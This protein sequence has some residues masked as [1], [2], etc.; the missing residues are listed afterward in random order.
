MPFKVWVQW[1]GGS[2]L[3][4]LEGHDNYRTVYDEDMIRWCIYYDSRLFTVTEETL[5]WYCV[6][7]SMA[8][9]SDIGEA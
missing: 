4:I 9:F 5:R 3:A 2:R 6:T 1:D 7:I 8:T